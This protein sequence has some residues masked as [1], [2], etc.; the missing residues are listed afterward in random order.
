MLKF[1]S[2]GDGNCLYNTEAVLLVYTYRQ[3]LL[4]PLLK[5]KDFV[6][7][8][9]ELLTQVQQ[10]NQKDI[11]L[12]GFKK[13]Y[14]EKSVTE[15]F[16]VLLQQFLTKGKK[17][18]TNW[19]KLQEM[20]AKG[21][22]AQ[23]VNAIENDPTIKK[24]I[25]IELSHALDRSIE[26]SWDEKASDSSDSEN[27]D[28]S[29]NERE[30]HLSYHFEDMPEIEKKVSEIIANDRL[31]TLKQKQDAIK[32]WF[33]KGK[34]EG[35]NFY[36][37]GEHGITT[38]AVHSGELELKILSRLFHH[39]SR[40]S[41]RGDRR[42]ILDGFKDAEE[43]KK[44]PKDALVF[45]TEKLINHW[46]AELPDNPVS[47]KI[48]QEYKPQ[49]AQHLKAKQ[50][51]ENALLLEE[52][53]EKYDSYEQHHE[54]ELPNITVAQYCKVHGLTKK[55]FETNSLPGKQANSVAKTKEASEKQ[56]KEPA[57]KKELATEKKVTK[58]KEPAKKKDAGK[59]EQ[60]PTPAKANK[61]KAP[62][63]AKRERDWSSY[64]TM[65][66]AMFAGVALFSHCLILPL[67]LPLFDSLFVGTI[68][69][70]HN[71]CW[72]TSGITA[73]FSLSLGWLLTEK[74]HAQ[75]EG[76]TA[77]KDGTSDHLSSFSN[78]E[79]LF[80][81]TVDLSYDA[82]PLLMLYQNQGAQMQNSEKVVENNPYLTHSRNRLH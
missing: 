66:L 53:L 60:K 59:T 42:R 32:N 61:K 47:K 12:P 64:S 80:E 13:P 54:E 46:N 49:R 71:L 3:G 31:R 20:M 75:G 62:N 65:L 18:T 68:I 6:Q 74:I 36:L 27:E 39:V 17:K 72:L 58:K 78:E 37:Y 69:G 45:T 22:R 76:K 79:R 52:I 7:N 2:L 21:M 48:L 9:G 5:N 11:Q 30:I 15:A 38:E 55:Q 82:Q 14:T 29:D 35:F 56:T 4:A 19:V 73:A 63:D 28:A 1:E 10:T 26:M 25:T 51:S 43:A 41:A 40:F 81:D 77:E 34:R 44:H 8:L 24:E 50:K 16:D 23:V 33:F 70:G 57:K 67:L